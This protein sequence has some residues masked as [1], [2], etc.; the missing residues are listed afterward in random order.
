MRIDERGAR[1]PYVALVVAALVTSGGWAAAASPA[2]A[3][4]TIVVTTTDQEING[5]A[6]CSLQ[7]AI[8]SANLDDNLAP[9]P[10]TPLD[11]T[12]VLE[13]GCVAGSGADIIELPPLS[14]FNFTNSI[15]DYANYVGPS[16]TPIITS[17]MIIEGRGARL[18][19]SGAGQ[20][21]RAFVVGFGGDLDLREVHVKNFD[22][23]GGNGADGGGGGMGAGGAI[24]VDLGDL[25]V[26]WSTFEGNSATGGNG[27]FLNSA[28]GGGGG[29]LFGD[30][31]T[32]GGGGGGARGDGAP[33]SGNVGGGGGGR[34]TDGSSGP[35]GLPCGGEGGHGLTLE[36]P[37]SD[38]G[39][40]A[41]CAGGGGGGGTDFVPIFDLFCGGEGGTGMYGG[42]GGGGG[43]E[44]SGGTGG[45][46]AG[47]GGNGGDGGFGGGGGAA[48]W[49]CFGGRGQGGTFAGDGGDGLTD[50]GGGGAGLGGAV[51]GY[52][53]D[54]TISNSTF[55]FNSAIR[56]LNGG[57][58][59]RDGRGAGGAVFTVGGDLSIE[60]STIA[61]N[62]AITV[63]GGGGGA[64]VVY[65][66][67]GNEEASLELRNSIVAGNGVSECYTRNGVTT[68]G[69]ARNLITDS[70]SNKLAD[71]A[72]PGVCQLGRSRARPAP[73]ERAG[74]DPDHG[75]RTNQ[76]RDRRR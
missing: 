43:D 38:D 22:I 47:G 36:A 14:V 56:G 4:D 2:R 71:P 64:I 31:G 76:R 52:L 12:P 49:G 27:S 11:P 8:Y 7:E 68:T 54:V 65:D 70:T 32:N 30:G 72:C 74:S 15:S 75:R 39:E 62:E 73:D 46:G 33:G 40:D 23:S 25:R 48:G 37:G 26:Q 28:D 60:S 42:G 6:D 10:A 18:Q 13:T 44:G 59:S 35:P 66:P 50:G 57:G 53:S 69:S 9:D 58:D 24:Y 17:E 5:D 21:T 67:E 16:V 20:L 61:R 19:R 63:T 34:V 1:R 41:T 55:A 3:A 45:F 51:F 29:G